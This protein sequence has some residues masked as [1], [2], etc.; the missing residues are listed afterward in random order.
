[1]QTVNFRS[2]TLLFRLP[3]NWTAEYLPDGGAEFREPHGAG[4][5]H[6]NVVEFDAP[7]PVL[8]EHALD[9]LANY[10]GHEG[11]EILHLHNGNAFVAYRNSEH[12]I[13]SFVWEVVLPI[14][15]STLRLAAFSYAVRKENADDARVKEI[16]SMLTRE[17]ALATT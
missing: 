6:L 12:D 15:P 7:N 3:K 13:A 11:R 5:L 8:P 9:L 17:I 1:M 14:S 4:V 10:G 2:G 16:V